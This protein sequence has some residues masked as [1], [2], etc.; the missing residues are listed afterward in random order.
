MR[1]VWHL[2][3]HLLVF[4]CVSCYCCLLLLLLLLRCGGSCQG[5]CCGVLQRG[6]KGEELRGRGEQQQQQQ[7]QQQQEDSSSRR[8]EQQ[9]QL[10]AAAA[11]LQLCK[12]PIHHSSLKLS[13]RAR[14]PRSHLL[15]HSCI[16]TKKPRVQ[17]QRV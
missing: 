6:L 2:D 14:N 8:G 4:T 10:A 17:Q 5:R 7:Q 1:Y 12:A 13:R 16:S 3:N 11:A 9:E 15:L